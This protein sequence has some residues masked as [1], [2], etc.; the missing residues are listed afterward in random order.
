MSAAARRPEQRL[1]MRKKPE[2]G[3]DVARMNPQTVK[4]LMVKDRIE[5]V[6]AGKKRLELSVLPVEDVPPFEVHCNDATLSKH[7]VSDNTIATIR[8]AQDQRG[9]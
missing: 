5:V 7:G 6:I 1:R 2:V 8:S 4:Q 3:P 9:V